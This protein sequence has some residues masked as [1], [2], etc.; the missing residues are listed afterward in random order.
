MDRKEFFNSMAEKW[1]AR[2]RHDPDRIGEILDLVPIHQGDT[3]LDVGTGILIPFLLERIGGTGRISTIDMAD[4][5]IR[6]ARAK[7][8]DKRVRYLTGD[9]LHVDFP[10]STFNVI[11]CYAVF[12]RFEDQ[13]PAV[14]RMG[15]ATRSDCSSWSVGS[16]EE[17]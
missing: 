9:V 12:P 8:G 1:D 15:E 4:N 7:C 6:I 3:G 11:V 14:Q 13:R 17:Q 10:P 16:G 5:M 2:C